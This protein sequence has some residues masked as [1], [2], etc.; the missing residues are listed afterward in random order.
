VFGGD[1]G[2]ITKVVV[3][4]TGDEFV[5]ERDGVVKY[6]N[7]GVPSPCIPKKPVV[8]TMAMLTL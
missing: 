7:T 8:I 1:P 6:A 2:G 5:P 4:T 3:A